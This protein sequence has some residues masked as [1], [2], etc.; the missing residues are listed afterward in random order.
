MRQ[1]AIRY[2]FL[3]LLLAAFLVYLMPFGRTEGKAA[4]GVKAQP[5]KET[6][7]ERAAVAILKKLQKPINLDRGFDTG[8]PLKDALE[9]L[10]DRHQL[11]IIIDSQAFLD[12]AGEI[13]DVEQ[14]PVK[15]PKIA[16]IPLGTV[17]R[18]VLAQVPLGATYL[19]RNEFIEIVPARHVTR[20]R[21]LHQKV[22]A[23]FDKKP[24]DEALEEL[25]DATGVSVIVDQSLGDKAKT[26]VKATFKN[27]VSLETAVRLLADMAELKAVRVGNALYVT[28]RAKAD[29]LRTEEKKKE[30]SPERLD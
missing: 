18:L 21:I 17:L 11:T 4:V 7:K 26:N 27:D 22:T 13:G 3:G 5:K 28:S 25:A 24:L 29:A 19:I 10:S 9:L 16:N 14:V 15:L 23:S 12:P 6:P 30:E 1:R 20:G 8:T 2:G